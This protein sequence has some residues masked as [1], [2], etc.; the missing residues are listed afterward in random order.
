MR[1]AVCPEYGPPEVIRV[2]ERTAPTAGPGQVRVRVEAAAVNYPDV[3]LVAGA[4]QVKVA[5]PFVPGSEFAGV[6]DQIGSG[7]ADFAVGDRVSGTGM[8]G[9]FAQNVVVDPACLSPVPGGID[10]RTAAAFGVAHRTAYHALRSTARLRSGERLV[11]LGAGGGVGLAAVQLGAALGAH[12]TAVASSSEKLAAAGRYGAARL[13][14]HRE[15]DVRA[16]L[17]EAAPDG[18]DVV[19]DPVGG[20]LSEPALRSL[21]WGGRFVTIGFAS[22]EIPRIPLNLVLIKGVHVLGFQ[23]QDVAAAEFSRNEA[24]LRELLIAGRAAPH[25]GAVYPLDAVAEAL[26]H[27]GD[28]RAV[29]KVL[30]DLR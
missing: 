14:N 6:I 15:C 2:E 26:H 16:A 20:G 22:G 21:A 28:G 24:E 18:T 3:L 12:V 27:V 30:I 9:A 17:R 29:G 5:P 10:A 4:Y 13:I 19:L 25:V 11:V 1:A 8:V 23:F 7:V